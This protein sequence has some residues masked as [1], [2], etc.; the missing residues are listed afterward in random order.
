[1]K[2][3][4][5]SLL[6]TL[7]ISASLSSL[8]LNSH[9]AIIDYGHYFSDSVSGLDWLDVTRSVNRSYND[10]YNQLTPGGDFEGWRYATSVEFNQL[11]SRWTGISPSAIGR[12]VTTGTSPSVDGLVTLFGSTLDARWISAYGQT[13]DQQ[14]GYDEG[15]GLDFTLGILSDFANNN[16]NQRLVASLWDNEKSGAAI[17][18]YNDSHRTLFVDDKQPDIGSFLVRQSQIQQ[19][20]SGAIG[21][22]PVQVSEPGSLILIAI[23]LLGIGSSRL[24]K[25]HSKVHQ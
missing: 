8:S 11:V 25:K 22:G 14:R 24:R 17:D 18:F 4:L 23:G 2:N 9:A 13:W 19:A 1:M 3:H 20:P 21:N 10:V 7:I 15:E 12:T 5:K 6:P 16:S